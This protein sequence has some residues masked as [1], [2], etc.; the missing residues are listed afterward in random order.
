M[1]YL[2][3]KFYGPK[4]KGGW[5]DLFS[6]AETDEQLLKEV[7]SD[8]KLFKK[9]S[10][11]QVVNVQTK[12][13]VKINNVMESIP[14]ELLL[15]NTNTNVSQKSLEPVDSKDGINIDGLI[16][17][18]RMVKKFFEF[19]CKRQNIH[20]KKEVL[21][22]S[23]PWSADP[24]LQRYKFCN[25]FRELD[26]GT[27]LI[28][29][30]KGNTDMETFVNIVCYRFFNRRDHFSRIGW[31][32]INNWDKK[33]FVAKLDKLKE[34]GPIFGDAYLVHGSH[35][36]VADR[37][38]WIMLQGNNFL[39]RLKKGIPSTGQ[40]NLEPSPSASHRVLKEIPG[41]GNFLAYQIWLDC[42]YHDLH[43]WNGDDH[44]VIGPGSE[45][46]LGLMLGFEDC[47]NVNL[48]DAWCAKAIVVLRDMQDEMFNK[49]TDE[50]IKFESNQRLRLDSIEHALCE[51]R[52]Y[53][54]LSYG[55]GRRRIFNN[56]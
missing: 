25:I 7:L 29:N 11:F 9:G 10:V 13:M 20:H 15:D 54:N 48:K 6:I 35:S 50:G 34:S 22:E 47:K 33:K 45:W 27:K 2:I 18:N 42:S 43:P 16:L 37:L 40:I 12:S 36:D 55:V 30:Q 14:D 38:E 46:G 24:I 28:M 39:D 51:W 19:I 52:K 31:I 32:D 41:V 23:G 26:A 5:N 3:F 53:H 49:L 1:K 56:K 21:K 44:V 8:E 4:P 17:P